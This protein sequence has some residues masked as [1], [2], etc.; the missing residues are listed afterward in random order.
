MSKF[1]TTEIS[2]PRNEFDGL[3]WI[4]VKSPALKKRADISIYVPNEP[5][6]QPLDAVILLHGVYGSHWAW[7]MNGSVHKTANRLIAERKMKPMV[8]IMPSDGLFGDGSGYLKHK[9]EDYE[10][11]IVDDVITVIKE[12][13]EVV[14]DNSNFFISGLSMGGYGAL[15]LGAKHPNTFRSFSGLSSITD[16]PQLSQFLEKEDF[17]K[18]S[19]VAL[20]KESV[21]ECILN[22]KS[23]ILPFHFDCGTDDILIELNRELHQSLLENKIEHSYKEHSG[24]HQWDYWQ[25]HIEDSLLFFD[26]LS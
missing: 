17:E 22:N 12:Q 15:R 7:T 21:L 10:N 5:K 16:F 6:E 23:H 2:N 14:N 11:W 1:F 19:N 20:K 8:L 18:L 24:S 4:T 9:D 3:R 13:I 26:G 25:K